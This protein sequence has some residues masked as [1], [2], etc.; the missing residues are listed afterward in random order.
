MCLALSSPAH[1]AMDVIDFNF[2]LGGIGSGVGF[3]EYY[4]CLTV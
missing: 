3:D 1:Q 4:Y 2:L